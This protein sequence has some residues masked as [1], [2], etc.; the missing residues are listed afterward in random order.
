MLYKITVSHK[1]TRFAR[2]M[3]RLSPYLV[4][5]DSITYLMGMQN[6]IISGH[7][8][9]M[10]SEPEFEPHMAAAQVHLEERQECENHPAQ[11]EPGAARIQNADPRAV[12]LWLVSAPDVAV[13][14][15]SQGLLRPEGIQRTD[16]HNLAN[17]HRGGHHMRKCRVVAADC[18]AGRASCPGLPCRSFFLPDATRC[19]A[20]QQ[21]APLCRVHDLRD[22]RSISSPLWPAYSTVPIGA[23]STTFL[24]LGLGHQ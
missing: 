2:I 16:T 8:C 11:P 22:L 12:W 21:R 20:E 17:V 15:S 10:H 3:Q 5:I 24:E 1:S 19:H 9:K 18:I 7:V 4:Y 13:S 23:E 14:D 6:L